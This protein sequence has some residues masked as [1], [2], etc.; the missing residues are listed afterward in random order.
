MYKKILGMNAV[1][2]TN[3]TSLGLNKAENATSTALKPSPTASP[4]T[5]PSI[6]HGSN[7]NSSEL[8]VN[9]ENAPS[10]FHSAVES[11]G[12]DKVI[13][14]SPYERP[15]TS[16]HTS[17]QYLHPHRVSPSHLSPPTKMQSDEDYAL[18][19]QQ[20]QLHHTIPALKSIHQMA[21]TTHYIAVDENPENK[22][23]NFV[24]VN[25]EEEEP[26]RPW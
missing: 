11:N 21:T 2:T 15:L 5:V 13:Y 19:L 23:G 12:N 20:T 6:H 24:N 16:I 14:E 1:Q 9:D 17:Q 4:V 22:H 8:D 25:G 10:N 18:A 26:W 7:S 3:T